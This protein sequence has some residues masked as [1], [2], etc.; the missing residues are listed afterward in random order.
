MHA[1]DRAAG[2]PSG[3]DERTV[4]ESCG[5]T[6]CYDKDAAGM[7]KVAEHII[8]RFRKSTGDE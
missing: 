8:T 5:L 7:R 6:A 2:D 4:F 3:C 1:A